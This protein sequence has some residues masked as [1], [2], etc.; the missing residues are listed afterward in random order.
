MPARA[1]IIPYIFNG[2]YSVPAGIVP[3]SRDNCLGRSNSLIRNSFWRA[4]D[5]R[6]GFELVSGQKAASRLSKIHKA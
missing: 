3:P 2:H 1:L 6:I 5:P 4:H